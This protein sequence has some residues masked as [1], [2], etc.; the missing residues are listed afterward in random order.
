MSTDEAARSCSGRRAARSTWKPRAAAWRA[1]AAPIPED[2]PVTTAHDAPRSLAAE[3]CTAES[4]SAQSA[5][6]ATRTRASEIRTDDTRGRRTPHLLHHGR[7]LLWACDAAARSRQSHLYSFARLREAVSYGVC[8]LGI[9]SRRLCA[10]LPSV[11][12]LVPLPVLQQAWSVVQVVQILRH[13]SAAA[14]P[15]PTGARL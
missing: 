10:A 12:S 11:R 9:D 3:A 15:S 13:A 4:R 14:G 6:I 1:A 2:A 8:I 5:N 7:G